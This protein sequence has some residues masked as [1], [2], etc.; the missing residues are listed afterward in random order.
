MRSRSTPPSQRFQIDEVHWTTKDKLRLRLHGTPRPR[1]PAGPLR[2]ASFVRRDPASGKVDTP[3]W[4]FKEM[5]AW[6]GVLVSWFGLA[7]GADYTTHGLP[8]GVPYGVQPYVEQIRYLRD[9]FDAAVGF[10]SGG[11][12]LASAAGLPVLR[13]NEY[14]KHGIGPSR[15]KQWGAKYNSF[16]AVASNIGLPPQRNLRATFIPSLTAFLAMLS[17]PGNLLHEGEHHVL[18]PGIALTQALFT[19]K[20]ALV[21]QWP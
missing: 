21:H 13:L 4:F 5:N 10:N 3:K 16:L 11:L 6:P 8:N 1:R 12:D 20:T 7:N 19:G 15:R 2:I 17:A 18:D 14:Q 9:N